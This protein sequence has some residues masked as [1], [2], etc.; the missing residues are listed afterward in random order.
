M[1]WGL[2]WDCSRLVTHVVCPGDEICFSSSVHI[3]SADGDPH[4]RWPTHQNK[5]VGSSWFSDKH[6]S[7][8]LLCEG[9]GA[10][11]FISGGSPPLSPCT[12]RPA[13][14]QEPLKANVSHEETAA[15]LPEVS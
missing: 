6:H 2:P 9:Q 7:L 15:F 10:W 3:P 5:R 13:V 4:P 12:G 11:R 1:S 14:P 8:S